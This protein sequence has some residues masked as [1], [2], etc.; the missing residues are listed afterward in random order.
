MN[1]KQT[2]RK[3]V[4]QFIE[5]ITVTDLED[6]STKINIDYKINKDTLELILK[7][8]NQKGLF[9]VTDKEQPITLKSS[10][11]EYTFF[12]N[13]INVEIE[14]INCVHKAQHGPPISKRAGKSL[15]IKGL[16]EFS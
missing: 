16:G 13:K 6:G 9:A 11:E 5:K 4:H 14:E 8:N 7:I 2:V 15:K 1:N 10:K 12:L 3:V